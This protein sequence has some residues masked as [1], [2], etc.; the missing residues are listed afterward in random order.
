VDS[1]TITGGLVRWLRQKDGRPPADGGKLARYRQSRTTWEGYLMVRSVR[2]PVTALIGATLLLTACA[3][4]AAPAQPASSARPP[5]ATSPPAAAAPAAAAPSAQPAPQTVRF[6]QVPTTVFAPLYVA[7][8]K[9]YFQEQGIVPELEIVTAGQDSMALVAQGQLDGAV[10]GFSAAT[11]NAIDRGLELRVVS[12]MGATPATGAPSALVVRKELLDS[13]QVKTMADLR[14]RKVALAGG[15]G[16][17]GSYWLAAMLREADLGLGDVEIVNLAF[18][19]MVTAFK[20]GSVDAGHM[21]APFPA[22]IERAGAGEIFGPRNRVGASA[23][24][25]IYGASFM[26][27]RDDAARRFFVALVRGA[28]DLQRGYRE[29]HLEIFSKYTRLP[30]ETLRTIDPYYFDPDMKPDVETLLDMQRTYIDAGI[31]TFSQPLPPERIADD[32][33]SRA[34][35]AQLGPYRP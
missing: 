8:E 6:A 17:N 18:P 29:D 23:V 32:S 4:A 12:A 1:P 34:A 25:T 16:S 13:G 3:A 20:R 5:S 26:R 19:D 15:S 21:A 10:A 7:I 9:G 28:R 31:L 33:Y 27:D 2:A 24:G 30:V 22:E 35:V 14:G 11:F